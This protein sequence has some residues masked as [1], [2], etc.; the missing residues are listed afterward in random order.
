MVVPELQEWITEKEAE[1]YEYKKSWEEAANDPWIIF[2]TSG[3]TGQ[4]DQ[5]IIELISVRLMT[6][7]HR[8]SQAGHIYQSHDDHVRLS[9]NTVGSNSK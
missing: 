7:S 1:L 3:T 4:F 9:T 5:L 8:T 6:L 2:H